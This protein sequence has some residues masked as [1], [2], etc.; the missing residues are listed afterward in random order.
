[1][2]P[3]V[4]GFNDLFRTSCTETAHFSRLRRFCQ[5]WSFSLTKSWAWAS[6]S[7][8]V[9]VPVRVAGEAGESANKASAKTEAKTNALIPGRKLTVKFLKTMYF[10][11]HGLVRFSNHEGV[12][13]A[14]EAPGQRGGR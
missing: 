14:A 1:M 3:R 10:I 2:L 12:K 9:R 5:N 6:R 8:A 11:V 13:R 7:S 4:L